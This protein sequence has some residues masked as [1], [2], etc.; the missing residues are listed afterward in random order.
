M[1]QSLKVMQ[2]QSKHI[3]HS[4]SASRGQLE[5]H[6]VLDGQDKDNVVQDNYKTN[7]DEAKEDGH[8][9]EGI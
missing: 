7:A 1:A 5:L 6:G 4:Q 2:E 3:H 8:L 9:N